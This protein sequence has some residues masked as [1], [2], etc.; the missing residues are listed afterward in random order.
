MKIHRG[1]KISGYAMKWGVTANEYKVSF[2]G[3]KIIPVFDS[4]EGCPLCEY[5]KYH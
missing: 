5:N 2:E 1:R 3:K 4:G